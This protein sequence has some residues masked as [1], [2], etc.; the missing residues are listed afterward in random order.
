MHL[1]QMHPAYL[2]LQSA[3]LSLQI[4]VDLTGLKPLRG[5]RYSFFVKDLI[6]RF[7]STINNKS[8]QRLV[9]FITSII[10]LLQ[11]ILS[12][13]VDSFIMRLHF[14]FYAVIYSL[15][16]L[17]DLLAPNDFSVVWAQDFLINLY[18]LKKQ[19]FSLKA[20]SQLAKFG[21]E[22]ILLRDGFR[23]AS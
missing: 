5:L 4:I 10:V 15:L 21:Y 11:S 13:C 8:V 18:L 23:G 1:D 3:Q 20:I 17:E 16:Q 7:I 22:W 2:R 9:N 19:S 6:S 12:I 14:K